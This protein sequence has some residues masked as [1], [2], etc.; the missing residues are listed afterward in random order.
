MKLG[1]FKYDGEVMSQGKVT[2]GEGACRLAQDLQV[3]DPVNLCSNIHSFAY[4]LFDFMQ[5]P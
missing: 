3:L 4:I 2:S 1:S 5:V